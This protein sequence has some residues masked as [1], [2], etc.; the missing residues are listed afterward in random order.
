LDRGVF[1][2]LELFDFI[3]QYA[4]HCNMFRDGRTRS[5]ALPG[6]GPAGSGGFLPERV[7]RSHCFHSGLNNAA[8]AERVIPYF[9]WNW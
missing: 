3:I 2:K 6:Y 5:N 9:A 4:K 7:S 8:A 1:T